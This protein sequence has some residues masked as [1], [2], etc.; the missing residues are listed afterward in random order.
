MTQ[1]PAFCEQHGAA[2]Y[3]Q[4]QHLVHAAVKKAEFARDWRNRRITHSDLATVVGKAEPLPPASLQNVT[5]ALDAVNAVLNTISNELL[6]AEIGNLITATPRARAFLSYARQ[7][8]DSAKFIDAIVDP[9]GAA[10]IAD[11][12]IATAF[13]ERLGLKPTMQNVRYVIEL[14]EAARRFA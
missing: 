2:L 8:A 1:L 5:S 4:V 12:D 10:R 11:I 14:R 13:L 6:N 3:D 7:L 9:D